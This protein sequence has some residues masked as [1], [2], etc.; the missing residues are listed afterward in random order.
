MSKD[1]T[2]SED[3]GNYYIYSNKGKELQFDLDDLT[4]EEL[5]KFEKMTEKQ[6]LR[7]ITNFELQKESTFQDTVSLKP[8]ITEARNEEYNKYA[9]LKQKLDEADKL[10]DKI[11]KDVGTD[12]D[13]ISILNEDGKTIK[14]EYL[15]FLNNINDND[16]K[17]CMS[18]FDLKDVSAQMLKKYFKKK[19]EDLH[20]TG[21][22]TS[23]LEALKKSFKKLYDVIDEDEGKESANK[24]TNLSDSINKLNNTIDNLL[25]NIN[26]FTQKK[27]KRKKEEKESHVKVEE[28]DEGK[29]GEDSDIEDVENV[30]VDATQIFKDSLIQLLPKNNINING[31]LYDVNKV[32]VM[33]KDYD[34]E[35][36]YNYI[37]KF[38]MPN[39]E[40]VLNEF[41]S[42]EKDFKN[43]RYITYNP[44][45]KIDSVKTETKIETKEEEPTIEEE[46]TKIE[47]KKEEPK[48]EEKEE[49]KEEEKKEDEELDEKYYPFITKLFI[50]KDVVENIESPTV[51]KINNALKR[52]GINVIKSEY[53]T[54]KKGNRYNGFDILTKS[55]VPKG[56]IEYKYVKSMF[57]APTLEQYY[58]YVNDKENKPLYKIT[59]SL[60]DK[61][62]EIDDDENKKYY[63]MSDDLINNINKRR[64]V[65]RG[66]IPKVKLS[67][68]GKQNK[69][70]SL[71]KT[72]YTSG[73]LIDKIKD[74]FLK[75]IKGEIEDLKKTDLTHTNNIDVLTNKLNELEK[76]IKELK[77]NIKFTPQTSTIKNKPSFLADIIKQNNLKPVK[78]N[79]K[80]EKT[81]EELSDI[82]KI[83]NERRKDIEYS[84]DSE[85]SDSDEWGEG[86]AKK[87]KLLD[88]LNSLE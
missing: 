15:E 31:K 64:N 27:D 12:A 28:F 20:L 29:Q 44:E 71:Y 82:E 55:L 80:K 40:S 38:N 84:E 18:A 24:K 7:F 76:T 72:T 10:Y 53:K 9:L 74:R 25:F 32:K 2:R 65:A 46:K 8:T 78:P 62:A 48:I 73:S 75:G 68:Y 23:F 26:S 14:D 21:I 60:K 85:D 13:T 16:I 88:F 86:Y 81:F 30:M 70:G 59:F 41:L 35:N 5:K 58:I 63:T 57:G 49:K 39:I 52:K 45:E 4:T 36:L 34:F 43:M 11:Y 22:R 54:T 50:I 61:K 83:L 67:F 56:N 17:N 3:E 77:E 6:R 19:I 33:L 79:E 1:N 66:Y 37:H 87:I 69:G 51:E 42:T 47:E